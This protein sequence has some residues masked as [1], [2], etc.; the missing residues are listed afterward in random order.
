MV[1]SPEKKQNKVFHKLG[2]S[3]RYGA[4]KLHNNWSKCG[5]HPLRTVFR[6]NK[7]S[8]LD[9]CNDECH[10]FASCQ[11]SENSGFGCICRTGYTGD[12]FVCGS[13][14]DLDGFPDQNLNCSL[15]TCQRDNCLHIPNSGQEDTDED[16]LGDA[17]DPDIDN[18]GILNKDD[19]CKTVQNSAQND[20][21]EDG[22]GDTCDICPTVYNPAQ[23]DTDGDGIGDDCPRNHREWEAKERFT[24]FW[25]IFARNFQK[26]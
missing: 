9:E 14:K 17:C 23:K 3:N 1:S 16:G 2:Q 21:D 5:N 13:D 10:E 12:G 26:I 15:L 6:V 11:N 24:L 4:F 20:I 25:S 19:N 8:L 22:V 7:Q 18:D